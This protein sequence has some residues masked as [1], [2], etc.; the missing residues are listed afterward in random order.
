MQDELA[1]R[2]RTTTA[3]PAFLGTPLGVAAVVLAFGIVYST[4]RIL[5]SSAIGTDDAW[6]NVYVQALRPGYILAQPPLYEWILWTVQQALGTGVQSFLVVKFLL[7]TLSALFLFGAAR[8]CIRDPATAALA[9]FSYV[10]FYQIGWNMLE[11]VTHTAVLVCACAATAFTLA[12]AVTTGRL[13][14]YLLLGLALGAGLLSKFGFPLFAGSLMVAF[15]TEPLLRRRVRPAGLVLA[16][17]VALIVASPFIYWVVAGER[18][19]LGTVTSIMTE[20]AR[21]PHL[22]RA[23][24]GIGRLILSLIGFAVPLVPLVLLL[25]W[26]PILRRVPGDDAYST[27]IASAF[28]KT[29][30]IS[31]GV[32]LV[33]IVVTGSSRLRERHMHPFLLLLPIWLFARIERGGAPV[34]RLR[35]FRTLIVAAV[36]LV[37]AIRVASFVAPDATFC[38]KVCRVSK[39]YHALVDQLRAMGAGGTLVGIDRYT[40]G[41]LRAGFPAARILMATEPLGFPTPESPP[42]PCWVVWE[43]G[44]QGEPNF[45]KAARQEGLDPADWP[46]LEPDR[47]IIGRWDHLWKPPGFRLTSWGVRRADPS[48]RGCSGGDLRQAPAGEEVVGSSRSQNAGT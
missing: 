39:P 6:E 40:A 13:A 33:A 47:R 35:M 15:L 32:A 34:R 45:E 4:I 3:L 21:Q 17:I 25:F 9:S 20:G 42:S 30:L 18:P 1:T 43:D 27:A 24:S 16:A 7:M 46:S 44:E 36:G 41:N 48:A 5:A 11:G 23:S 31:I 28:G 10:L 38:G 29:I 22:V 12:R 26:R 14:D 19:V 8:F 37:V 2:D